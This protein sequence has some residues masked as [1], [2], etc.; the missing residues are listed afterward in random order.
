MKQARKTHT[1]Y[2]EN[3]KT[4]LGLIDKMDAFENEE[5]RFWLFK[6][7]TSAEIALLNGYIVNSGNYEQ[8]HLSQ[9]WDLRSLEV[10]QNGAQEKTHQANHPI[11]DLAFYCM[12]LDRQD[13]MNAVN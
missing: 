8:F 6:N 5:N 11:Y 10:V 7:L 1:A 4:F 12:E 9:T 2:G 13:R 3:Y